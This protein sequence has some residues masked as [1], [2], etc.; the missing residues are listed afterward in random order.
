MRVRPLEVGGGDFWCVKG[1]KNGY[2]M[3]QNL[4]ANPFIIN[5]RII[6]WQ[7]RPKVI[8]SRTVTD[9]KWNLKSTT[10]MYCSPFSSQ[11]CSFRSPAHFL[12]RYLK[13]L[14][15]PFLYPCMQCSTFSFLKLLILNRMRYFSR[16]QIQDENMATVIQMTSEVK[17]AERKSNKGKFDGN[18]LNKVWCL[19]TRKW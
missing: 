5:C 3:I 19:N 10:P 15:I 8:L 7:K 2:Y 17:A 6:L 1:A 14:W 16:N 12:L 13:L 4:T 9:Q 18:F 11:K